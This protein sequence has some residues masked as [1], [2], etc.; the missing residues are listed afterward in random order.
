MLTASVVANYDFAKVVLDTKPVMS[1][2]WQEHGFVCQSWR[3]L[4]PHNLD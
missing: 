3:T 1:T 4:G 2:A